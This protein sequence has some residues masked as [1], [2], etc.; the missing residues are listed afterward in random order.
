MLR[1]G[2][3][4]KVGCADVEQGQ[5]EGLRQALLQNGQ[6]RRD[7][8]LG[9]LLRRLVPLRGMQVGTTSGE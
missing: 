1:S 4:A 9:L 3:C 2:G 5:R 6:A 7:Q 8:C